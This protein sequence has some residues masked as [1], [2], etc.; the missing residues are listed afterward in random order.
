MQI[1]TTETEYCKLNVHYEENDIT[2]ISE[3]RAEIVS[4]YKGYKMPGFRTGKGTAEAAQVYYRSQIKDSLV[5]QLANEAYQNTLA[6]KQLK[7][8]GQPNFTSYELNGNRFTCDFTTFVA[9]TFTLGQYRDF[10]I[11][12]QH[13]TKT[14][15]EIAQKTMQE[16]RIKFGETV[17]YADNDFVQVD[18]NVVLTYSSTVD[19]EKIERL[20]AENEMCKV[21][22]T[23]L[24]GFDDQLLGMKQGEEKSFSLI[25]PKELNDIL[26]GKEIRFDVKVIL[27]AKIIPAPLDEE[28]AKKVGV[29]DTQEM[30]GAA[31]VLAENKLKEEEDTHYANQ[32]SNRLV[33]GH[34]FRIP[35]W[36]SA[37]ESK[38][39]ASRNGANWDTLTD[40]EKEQYVA[41]AE[42]S[43][44]L[45]LVLNRIREEMPETQ[46]T[47][48]ETFKIIKDNFAKF[49]SEPDKAIETAYNN[50]SLQIL[51]NRAKDD[52]ALQA[53]KKTCTI[54]E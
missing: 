37:A 3:K 53:I 27:G 22:I 52:Y 31:K 44:K 25:M 54:V 39:V 9:P 28:L 47:E 10:E 30:M 50:G 16:L 5:Q 14:S 26:A 7:P 40:F 8:F 32:I 19:G 46:L 12:K 21:G 36:L 34:D 2:T 42:K 23:P 45:S 11:P 24:P 6:E 41:G 4:K 43:I 38:F 17:P 13:Q 1:T 29:K 49:S 18:D 20:T 33:A 48:E 51:M 35:S 15:E